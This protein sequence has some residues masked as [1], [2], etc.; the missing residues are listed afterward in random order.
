MVEDA[1][2][3]TFEGYFMNWKGKHLQL[4]SPHSI[5]SGDQKHLET[6]RK[7]ASYTAGVWNVQKGFGERRGANSDP[8]GPVGI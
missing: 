1:C 2:P 4:V 8:V 7:L 5:C 3:S 6:P